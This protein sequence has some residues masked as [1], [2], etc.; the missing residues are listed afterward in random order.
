MALK[1]K[2]ICVDNKLTGYD[3]LYAIKTV[4]IKFK[5]SII[6]ITFY[7]EAIIYVYGWVVVIYWYHSSSCN[8]KH[9]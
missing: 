1:K 6:S 3:K 5:I 7:A 2:A 9:I 8:S 4:T